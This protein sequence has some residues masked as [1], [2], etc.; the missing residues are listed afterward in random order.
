MKR[1]LSL[2]LAAIMILCICGCKA[3]P[4]NSS[5]EAIDIEYEE[6]IVD[7]SGN[8][9]TSSE[10]TTSSEQ[11][12]SGTQTPTTSSSD[13]SSNTNSTV[14]VDN[15]KQIDYNTVVEIDICNDVVRAYLESDDEYNQYYLLSANDGQRFD[16]QNIKLSWTMD[17][18]EY[19]TVYFSKNA[20]FSNAVTFQSEKYSTEIKGGMLIPGETYYWKVTGQ[21]TNDPL[22]GGKIKVKDAPVRWIYIDGVR[23]VRDMGGWKTTSGKK[24]KYGMLYRGPQLNTEKDG[25]VVNTVKEKGLETFNKLGIKTEFDLR[26]MQNVHVQTQ[27]TNLNYVLLSNDQSD[28]MAYSSI[29]AKSQKEKYLKMFEYLSDSSN[30][31]IYAHCQGGADRTGTYAFLLNGLLGVSY[32]DL[33]RDFEM[34]SFAGQKRWRSA[35]NGTSFSA[36]DAD[37]T[38]GGVTVKWRDLYKY[39]MEYGK[40]NGCT[41]L[42]Q[43]IEH[44]FVNY[45]GVPQ[46]QID[47][48]KNIMLE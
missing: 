10:D 11:N 17:G 47:S 37:M 32:E 23:N 30:Y 31:P 41:T 25:A 45:V 6:I 33:T 4:D 24:V 28:Y 39:I 1:V 2:L 43:S 29:S 12:E 27:G 48:F 15:N 8:T 3:E 35:G 36:N 21:K 7:Q 46:S 13:V 5:S 42:E 18:S 14:S 22:G 9:I 16:H 20:D 26:S 38:D 19:Y 40:Q 34:T 44:W